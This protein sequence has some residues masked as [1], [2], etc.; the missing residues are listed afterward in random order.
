MCVCVLILSHFINVFYCFL[1]A[2]LFYS[3]FS[4]FSFRYTVISSEN[5]ISFTPLIIS[6]YVFSP[7]NCYSCCKT[8]LNKWTHLYCS[9]LLCDHSSDLVWQ[10]IWPLVSWVQDSWYS[11]FIYTSLCSKN[12]FKEW[13][14]VS[15][16]RK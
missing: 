16:D 10:S 14:T 15:V 1:L 13:I 8:N 11:Y 9:W 3:F 5:N 12:I 7:R 2:L 4:W 6:S